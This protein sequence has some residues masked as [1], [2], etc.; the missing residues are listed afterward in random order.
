MCDSLD[1]KG[2]YLPE[3]LDS[4]LLVRLAFLDAGDQASAADC[5]QAYESVA[6]AY[7]A[8]KI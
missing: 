1:C 6:R 4:L 5:L 3:M 8:G 2:V 7:V